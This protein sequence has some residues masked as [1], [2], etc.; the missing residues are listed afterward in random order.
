MNRKYPFKLDTPIEEEIEVERPVPVLSDDKKSATVELRTVKTKVKT[1][2][3][4]TTEKPFM[5]GLR[6]HNWEMVDRHKYIA[7]C[8]NNNCMKVRILSPMVHT[9]KDGHIVS[10][11]TKEIID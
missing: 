11:Y 9:I 2:Y 10:R 1:V 6:K 3:T 4:E 8:M 7:K 5:C